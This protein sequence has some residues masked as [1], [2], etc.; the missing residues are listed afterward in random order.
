MKKALRVCSAR[1]SYFYGRRRFLGT[2]LG[3]AALAILAPA[4]VSAC[5]GG[6]PSST[7]TSLSP[8]G[9]S[10]AT[11]TSSSTSSAT[12]RSAS[13]SVEAA[14]ACGCSTGVGPP[15][16]PRFWRGRLRRLRAPS[17][18]VTSAPSL[19]GGAPPHP[20]RFAQRVG[21]RFQ[22]I[23]KGSRESSTSGPVGELEGACFRPLDPAPSYLLGRRSEDVRRQAPRQLSVEAA[24]QEGEAATRSPLRPI[25]EIVACGR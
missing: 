21:E 7:P 2:V 12:T 3:C 8:G 22:I 4:L 6:S 20:P 24:D 5:T 1:W 13:L 11:P 15:L 18:Q 14:T 17:K 23:A 9:T 25:T 19:V 10:P 16:R